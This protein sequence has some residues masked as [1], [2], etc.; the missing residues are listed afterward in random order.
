MVIIPVFFW[1]V[2]G[3]CLTL[4]FLYIFEEWAE[5]RK[6]KISDEL[7]DLKRSSR[8]PVNEENIF[9]IQAFLT[10]GSFVFLLIFTGSFP[11]SLLCSFLTLFFPPL[12]VRRW[13]KKRLEKLEEQLPEVLRAIAGAMRAG[14]SLPLAIETVSKSFSEPSKSEFSLM[15]LQMKLGALPEEA[16]REGGERTGAEDLLMFSSAVESARRSG[17]NLSEIIEKLAET[18]SK[19]LYIR[20][21]VRTLSAQ[22]RAQGYILGS[23]PFIMLLILYFLDKSMLITAFTHPLGI[24]LMMLAGIFEAVGIVLMKKI[25]TVEV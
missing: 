2:A 18:V 10:G 19:R 6:R 21:R 25:L 17:G 1:A 16:I 20:L 9:Y 7:A 8:P 13:K 22:G 4:F 24:A 3:L 14:K 15:A 5:R 12:Y 11:F 23:I